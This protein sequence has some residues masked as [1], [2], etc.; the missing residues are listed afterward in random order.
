MAGRKQHY[1][2][3]FLLRNF[4]LKGVGHQVSVYRLNEGKYLPSTAIKGQAHENNFYGRPSVEDEF[5]KLE[6][7]TSV[8]IGEAI[9]HETLPAR[10]S[11]GHDLLLTFTLAQV[12]R[13]R[14]AADA[15]NKFHERFVKRV[16]RDVPKLKEIGALDRVAVKV[17]DAPL[18][19]LGNALLHIDI[20]RDLAFKLLCNRTATPFIISDDPAVMYNQFLEPRKR[21]GCNTGLAVKGLQIFLPL[22]PRHLL[23]FFDPD[24]YTVGGKK[25]ASQ[26]VDVEA[27][28]DVRALNLLQAANAGECLYFN[29]QVALTEVQRLVRKAMPFRPSQK[30]R[31][32]EYDP[33]AGK[34]PLE[35]TL[36]RMY[37]PDLRTHLRLRC[38]KLTP[39]AE[40]YQ[41]G[42]RVIHYRDPLRCKLHKQFLTEVSKGTYT[43]SEF[44]KFLDAAAEGKHPVP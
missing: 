32:D 6:G 44:E 22:G 42:R 35:G 11:S 36:L 12:F 25:L 1:V 3:Q 4:S 10:R 16:L 23:V 9:A 7:G 39:H 18:Y 26:R 13:T 41:L 2:P 31:L 34:V 30:A 28:E 38:V 29:D 8:L 27:E 40:K 15:T 14:E 21:D 37:Q 17:V 24:V 43:P 19:T 5:A 20:T 33:P